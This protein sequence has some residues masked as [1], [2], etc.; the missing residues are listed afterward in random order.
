MS[1][2]E[3]IKALTAPSRE[4]RITE[5]GRADLQTVLTL[6]VGAQIAK[7]AFRRQTVIP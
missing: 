5:K 3:D 4:C 7:V 6:E 2:D 1:T